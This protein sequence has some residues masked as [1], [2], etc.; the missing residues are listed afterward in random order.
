MTTTR[1]LTLSSLFLVLPA[2][3]AKNPAGPDQ[4]GLNSDDTDDGKDDGEPSGESEGEV[5][6]E[7]EGEPEPQE[8]F[9]RADEFCDQSELSAA[10][11]SGGVAGIEFCA[12]SLEHYNFVW[13]TCM[14]ET[15]AKEG[16]SRACDGGTQYCVAH[17]VSAD[18]TETRWGACGEASECEPGEQKSCDFGNEGEGFDIEMGCTTD[19]NGRHIWNWDDC[20][21][22]LVLSFGDEIEFAPASAAAAGF[23]VHGGAG[24][25]ERADWPTASS[26]WLALDRDRNGTIDDGKELF[27]AATKMS[28]GTGPHNGFQALAELDSDRDGKITAS[29]AR[30]GELVLWADHDGDRRSSGWEMLP[31]ASFEIV[32]I[33]LGYAS[34]RECDGRGNCGL[35]RASFV[36]RSMGRQRTGEVVDV[37]VRC[38]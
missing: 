8:D 9:G 16:E 17:D 35:E 23:D 10:C 37:R 2:C 22:P 7:D 27:G 32:E 38:E 15:C 4:D 33:D 25:C 30:W 13:T 14:T 12:W 26:P 1:L 34:R 31:L 18:A 6:G 11:Q 29:D 28:S 19:E 3:D 21:T 36:Y 20:N 24:T 5:K